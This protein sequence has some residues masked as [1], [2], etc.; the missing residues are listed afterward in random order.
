MKS[1]RGKQ[2]LAVSDDDDL[3]TTLFNRH[4]LKGEF[5]R[6]VEFSLAVL[7][8][9]RSQRVG[10]WL[11]YHGMALRDVGRP[12]D[13]RVFFDAALKNLGDQFPRANGNVLKS[14]MILEFDLGNYPQAVKLCVDGK[15]CFHQIIASN[16][17]ESDVEHAQTQLATLLSY[18]YK[19]EM[20]RKNFHT[21][22][23]LINN[24]I[25][26]LQSCPLVRVP[27]S[28]Q[29][30]IMRNAAMLNAKI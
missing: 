27:E 21:A 11:Y 4:M 8:N 2:P 30:E 10:Q 6:A 23:L 5:P 17:A 28:E 18:Q 16:A 9:G 24:L 7:H 13:A 3:N 20:C 29:H 1:K 22:K 12:A 14:Y 19:A 26:F 15:Q 25:D